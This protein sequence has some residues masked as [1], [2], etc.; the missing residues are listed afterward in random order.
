MTQPLYLRHPR[1]HFPPDS[2]AVLV[3][4][5]TGAPTITSFSNP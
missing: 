2:V 3:D 1:R 5:R 4:S